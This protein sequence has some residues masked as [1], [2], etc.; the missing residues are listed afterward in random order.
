MPLAV[1]NSPRERGGGGQQGHDQ[2]LGEFLIFFFFELRQPQ[3]DPLKDIRSTAPAQLERKKIELS[4][5]N[6]RN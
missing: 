3:S 5:L 6:A 2:I 4:R 1:S